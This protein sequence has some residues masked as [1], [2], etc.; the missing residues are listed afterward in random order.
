MIFINVAQKVKVVMAVYLWFMIVSRFLNIFLVTLKN[1]SSNCFYILG[2]FFFSRAGGYTLIL[3]FY[4][5]PQ[6][7]NLNI[8]NGISLY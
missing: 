1:L 6:N 2:L 8:D 3:L 5:N 4:S 7:N